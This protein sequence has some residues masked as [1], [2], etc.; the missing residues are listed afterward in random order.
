MPVQQLKSQSWREHKQ[1]NKHTQTKK[2]KQGNFYHSDNNN[3]IIKLAPSI[4]RRAKA[5]CHVI[6][7]L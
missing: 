5:Y 2:T 7:R 4:K 6:E 1:R 3:S